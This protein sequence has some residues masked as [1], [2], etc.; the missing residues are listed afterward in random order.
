MEK[1]KNE[2][3]NTDTEIIQFKEYILT[4]EDIKVHCTTEEQAKNLL[5]WADSKGRKW[6]SGTSFIATTHWDTYKCNTYYNIEVGTY[7]AILPDS[8]TISYEE[9]LLE[10]ST[11]T[12]NNSK[13]EISLNSDKCHWENNTFYP[14]DK[15][16][17]VF[18]RPSYLYEEFETCPCCGE[19]LAKPVEIK[20]GQFGKFW[21]GDVGM[22]EWGV[23]IDILESCGTAKYCIRPGA[24]WDH[25]TPGLPEGYDEGGNPV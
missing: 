25:F 15:A 4:T 13:C 16:L 12:I 17:D 19:V 6:F 11:D 14:C 3:N 24:T 1:F 18:K 2:V 7:G 23:L 10:E 22:S 8:T 5:K 20:I 21:G 9:A